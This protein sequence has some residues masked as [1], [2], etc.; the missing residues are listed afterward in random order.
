[1]RKGRRRP[2]VAVV[3]TLV[4]GSCIL[5]GAAAA[6]GAQLNGPK[7]SA[8]QPAGGKVP[9][10]TVAD[11]KVT[12]DVTLITGDRVS[13]RGDQPAKIRPAKGREKVTFIERKEVN[14]DLTVVPMDADAAV[15]SGELDPR[16]FNVTQLIKHGFDDRS[17]SDIPLIVSGPVA[18][19]SGAGKSVSL[20]SIGGTAIR[21]GKNA[22]Y[23]T[24]ARN[25]LRT[26]SK[27]KQWI[28]LDGPV[29]AF[30]DK[31]VPQIGAPEAWKNGFTGKGIQVAV[32]D[33]GIDTTHPD[34]KDAVAAAKDFTDSSSGTIDKFGHGTH[35]ASIVTGEN[36]VYRGVAPDAKLLNGKVLDDNGFGSEA[37]IIAG[38]EW[39][40]KAGA[41]VVNMS[42]G[43]DWPSDG[44]DVMSLAVNR[45]TSETGALFVVA[46]GN[47]GGMPGSPAAAD[48]ALTVGAVD[49]DENLADFSSRGPRYLDNA[50]KPDITAPGVG[51][52]AAKAK[53]SVL[54]QQAPNVGKDHLELSGTS[55]AAP[56]VAGAAAILAQEHKDWKAGELKATLMGTAKPNP[57]LSVF[58]QGA[59][60]VDVAAVTKSTVRASVGSISNG[61]VRWPHQDDKP[62]SREVTYSNFGSAPVTLNLAAQVNDP[63]GK[64]A[65][66]EMFSVSPA[67]LTIPAGGKATAT[68]TTNTAVEG[69]DGIYTGVIAAGELRTP[70]T[71]DREVESYDVKV[72]FVG[73]DG[74]PTTNYGYRFVSIEHPT[75]VLPAEESGS[76][77]T[78]RLIKG[79]HYFE[80]YV[81]DEKLGKAAYAAEPSFTVDGPGEVTVDA[82]TGVP[83][84]FQVD[85]P[86]AVTST[87][88]FGMAR[89]TVWGGDESTGA[90]YLN[91][92]FEGSTVIP[93][94]TSAAPDAFRF[95]KGAELA[96]PANSS[97][98]YHLARDDLGRVPAKLVSR[99]RDRSLARVKAQ[100]AGSKP[101]TYGIR[102]GVTRALPFTLDELYTPGKAWYPAF[103]ESE[104]PDDVRGLAMQVT[105]APVTYQLGRTTTTRWGFPVFGPALPSY[106]RSYDSAGRIGDD[107]HFDIP[108]HTDSRAGGAGFA[109]TEGTTVLSK[110]GQVI[111]TETFPGYLER[112]RV[113]AGAGTYQ[114]HIVGTRNNP[115]SSRIVADWTFRSDSVTGDKPA[116]L[117]L[118]AVRFA[119]PAN[120]SAKVPTLLPITVDHNAGK[121]GKVDSLAVSHDGGATW[122]PVKVYSVGGRTLA[123]IKHPAGA[124]SVSLKAT[125]SDAEGNKVDQTIVNAF[126]LK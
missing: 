8:E 106:R 46:S 9:A 7:P 112:V 97:Y 88:V 95:L 29:R 113:P 37:G 122:Q 78:S 91:S 20:P 104:K 82:R 59:G 96:A 74:K 14:G 64:P 55:M 49:H 66:A 107:L 83:V 3:A 52:V 124:K 126:L 47:S 13:L 69:T 79:Q 67:S 117:P 93:S 19:R 27:S 61:I 71:V 54:G 48:S 26:K 75:A 92:T 58:E 115:L 98:Q 16:L 110:D 89:D 102:E 50:I 108:L 99:V 120:A 31:S 2:V 17:R 18:L 32:L 73:F 23:W 1:M 38:M 15:R 100:H 45:L 118:L 42:L 68:V 53:D 36:A 101:G 30:L 60:R 35:V 28:R 34:L 6:S 12:G 123:L 76:T 63:D 109:I 40:A 119:P 70:I 4:A 65:P 81:D 56:H 57:K 121:Q 125:A 90:I 72:N 94:R 87:A 33:T 103:V 80:A 43:S 111:A 86:D 84:G 105:A 25:A 11:S 21:I 24:G 85:K 41:E 77:T 62:I 44:T 51:I 5:G 116:P 22:P 39:A 10:R 114:L